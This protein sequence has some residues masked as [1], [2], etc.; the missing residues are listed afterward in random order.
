MRMKGSK[1]K[2]T[3]IIG[4]FLVVSV[5]A[6]GLIALYVNLVDFSDKKIR[7]ED[8]SELLLV[9]NTLSMLYEI[10]SGQ[11]ILSAES[12]ELYFHEYDSIT[13][14]IKDNLEEL[15]QNAHD[16]LRV[17]TLDTIAVLV[18]RK[19]ENL[20]ELA[21][22]LDSIRRAP[23]IVSSTQSS[24]VPR[25]LNRE[26]TDY[27][28]SRNLNKSNVER[29]DTSV[30]AGSKRGFLDRVKDVFV[31]RADSTLV[32][33]KKSTVSD[34]DLR[35]IVD[36][37]VQK[38]RY[39]ERLDLERQRH[40][41]LA[42]LV[43][44][45]L[46]NQTNRMLTARIDDL[47]K[48]IEHEELQKSIQ[49]IKEKER[50]ISR[51]QKT[52]FAAFCAALL[53]AFVFA[54]LF[55]I[56]I[57]RSQKYR[58]QLEESNKRISG[59][60][61]AREKLM[62]TISHD[63]KAPMSSILGFIDLLNTHDDPKNVSYL[64]NMK[65]SG[66]H[67]LALASALLDYH[68][69]EEG[70]WQLKED[71]FDLHALVDDTT[72]GFEPLASHKMLRYSV[73]NDLPHNLVVCGDYYMIR[74]IMNNLIS[75]AIKYT[76]KGQVAVRAR[77]ISE[78]AVNRLWFSVTDTGDGISEDDQ[79]V[80]FEEFKQLDNIAGEEGSGLGLAITKG[81]LEALNGTL[82]LY[83]QIG[84]GS[85]FIVELPLKESK[86]DAVKQQSDF[87]EETKEVSPDL[88]GVT[89]LLVD[90]DPIQLTMTS[91]TLLKAKAKSVTLDDPDKVL[92]L[93]EK[94]KFDIL[95]VDIQ[96]PGTDGLKLVKQIR[97]VENARIK[98]IPIIG[99]SARSDKSAEDMKFAGFTDFLTKPFTAARLYSMVERYVLG[100]DDSQ[101][102][103]GLA[104]LSADEEKGPFALIEFV[105]ED[106]PASIEILQ[107][108]VKEAADYC[109]KLSVAFGNDD[110]ATVRS[111]SHKMLPL[112]RLM[113]NPQ[114][115]LLMEK[116]EK[117]NL[118][119]EGEKTLLLE[120]VSGQIS[121]AK[122]LLETITKG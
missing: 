99:L 71:N 80:I 27:L 109:E 32:I 38:V 17:A 120:H 96:M 21:V 66:N 70:N 23:R 115:I 11:N 55:L 101:D 88:E 13:P 30:V 31:A 37:I 42:F 64:K 1:I 20:Q 62:L 89:V 94:A 9:G 47:L 2:S 73:E 52:M 44:Q 103:P 81:F 51:S 28:E 45:E 74:Q 107:S 79:K 67:I 19:K 95:F 91:E 102:A 16:S 7:N 112:F 15:K 46:M 97:R 4:Y 110:V 3:V 59:L 72:R 106:K 90:D 41:Q 63:I 84:K 119:A 121:K 10:E 77:L 22:L 93:V 8:L 35:L 100:I 14:K 76:R 105:K 57:N 117:G 49:L 87:S 108:F 40:F 65:N 50:T 12:A 83:S 82:Q 118:L 69:L 85:E 34:N 98:N 54:V 6:L 68:K 29:N 56:D 18:D 5:M 104:D 92:P 122:V 75:N 78:D 111:I 36:T 61:A 86:E 60:L 114:V 25:K 39:S 33:E 48:G 43:R 24:F 58:R 26:I 53:I 113:G 116:S